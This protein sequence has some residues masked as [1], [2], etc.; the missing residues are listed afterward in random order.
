MHIVIISFHNPF[1]ID[2]YLLFDLPN[3]LNCNYIL[4]F[5]FFSCQQ[6]QSSAINKA[7]RELFVCLRLVPIKNLYS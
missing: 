2:R 7:K 3:F 4:Y 5:T 6:K 1:V